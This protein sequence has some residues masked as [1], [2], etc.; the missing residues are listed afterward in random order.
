MK[1][2]SVMSNSRRSLI[3]ITLHFLASLLTANALAANAFSTEALDSALYST[4]N[5]ASPAAQREAYATALHLTRVLEG[6][7]SPDQLPL[8][9]ELIKLVEDSEDFLYMRLDVVRGVYG[10]V[11]AETVAAVDS[12]A[13]WKIE[14]YADYTDLI[15]AE[16]LYRIE[17]LTGTMKLIALLGRLHAQVTILMFVEAQ[18]LNFFGTGSL[19]A[20]ALSSRKV[21]V[22]NK[23]YLI[24]KSLMSET[25]ETI[26]K[27]NSDYNEY[28]RLIRLLNGGQ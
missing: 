4:L 24:L 18:T 21:E 6:F 23:H 26:E 27:T 11:S 5:A 2:R 10:R 8:L 14:N 19:N 22:L 25:T 9:K 17:G 13:R 7:D 12:L 16:E 20:Q 28:N 3:A 15:E 1:R